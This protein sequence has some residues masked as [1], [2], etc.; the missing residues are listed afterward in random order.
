LA[1]VKGPRLRHA[2]YFNV[3]CR[4]L[5]SGALVQTNAA[6]KPSTIAAVPVGFGC[7]EELLCNFKYIKAY[8]LFLAARLAPDPGRSVAEAIRRRLDQ[9]GWRS[10]Q[11][12]A[13]SLA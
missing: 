12:P 9:P 8:D 6:A 4:S 13:N 7:I 1:E 10:R 11:L 3:Y 2:R 5:I